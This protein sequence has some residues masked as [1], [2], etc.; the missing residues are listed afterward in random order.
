MFIYFFEPEFEPE[1][2][3][4]LQ[5]HTNTG[6]L[7]RSNAENTWLELHM[8]EVNLAA[9]WGASIYHSPMGLLLCFRH[10]QEQLLYICISAR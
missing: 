9:Q 7:L 6:H 1:N 8:C 10:D 2:Y 3:N 4:S 5:T